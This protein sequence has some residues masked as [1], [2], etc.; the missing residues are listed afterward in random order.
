MLSEISPTEKNKYH[1]SFES[2]ILKT[3]LKE[4]TD[5]AITPPV[6]RGRG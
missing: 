4:L 1:I 6:A 2:E 3:E 5:R